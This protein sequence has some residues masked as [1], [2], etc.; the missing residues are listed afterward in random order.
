MLRFALVA[1][2]LIGPASLLARASDGRSAAPPSVHRVKLS[3]L[4]FQPATLTVRPG[5]RIDWQ[6]DDLITH[7]VTATDHSFD[8][9][10][11]P[12]GKSWSLIAHREG[13]YHYTCRYH[14][15]MTGD[16]IVR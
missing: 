16:L 9:G 10:D 7:T 8:S 11:I 6:N 14:P 3:G 5:D 2:A 15:N 4:G 1:F 12:G 13:T